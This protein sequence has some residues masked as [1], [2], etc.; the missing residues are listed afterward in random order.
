VATDTG[1]AGE[2]GDDAVAT[3]LERDDLQ[4]VL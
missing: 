1:I 4:L 3:A 2:A